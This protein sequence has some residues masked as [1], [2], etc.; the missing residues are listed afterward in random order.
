MQEEVRFPFGKYKGLTVS[1]A[2][3]PASYL[4]WLVNKDFIYGP[5]KDAVYKRL[6]LQQ[7]PPPRKPRFSPGPGE[8]PEELWWK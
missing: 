1:S 2:S 5:L 4:R 6:G 7:L 3:V 8:E